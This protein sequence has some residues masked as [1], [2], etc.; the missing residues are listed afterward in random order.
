MPSPN[1]ATGATGAAGGR[2]AQDLAND[3]IGE[4]EAMKTILRLGLKSTGLGPACLGA[5]WAGLAVSACQASVQADAKVSV[6]GEEREAQDFDRPLET[7]PVV[8]PA[9]DDAFTVEEFALLGARHDLNYNGPKTAVCQCLAVTLQDRATHESLQWE[10]DVPRVEP[11]TQ[12]IIALSS[13]DVECASPPPGTLGA[14]Y[15]GYGVDGNDV[16]VYVEALGEGRPMT[17]GAVIPRPQGGG[18]VFVEAAGAI[19]GKPLGSKG[20]RCKIAAPGAGLQAESLQKDRG[21]PARTAT[22]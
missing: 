10:L 7:P 5:L 14:S 16:I 9:S 6:K 8:E 12:W 21:K 11:T 20:K 19:Y 17:S 2:R 4:S 1:P 22:R 13:N 3:D 18:S 15:Q